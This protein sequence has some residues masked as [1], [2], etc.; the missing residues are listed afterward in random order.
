[1]MQ[2]MQ[3]P[4]IHRRSPHSSAGTDDASDGKTTQEDYTIRAAS[5]R[6]SMSWRFVLLHDSANSV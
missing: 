1:M 6:Y 5:Y 3:L 4:R 2:T